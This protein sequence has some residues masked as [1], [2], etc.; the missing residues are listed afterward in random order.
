M[1]D[2]DIPKSAS[3]EGMYAQMALSSLVGQF[4]PDSI[5][6]EVAR[7]HTQARILAAGGLISEADEFEINVASLEAV[8]ENLSK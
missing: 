8:K 6:P 7:R 4:R 1:A 5:V 3:I 2:K